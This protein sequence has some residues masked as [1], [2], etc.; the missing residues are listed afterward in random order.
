MAL[1]KVVPL[2]SEGSLDVKIEGG[3]L[4][5]TISHVHASGEV[6]LVAKEDVKYFLEKLKVAIPGKFDDVVIDLAEASLP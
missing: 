6:S 5:L 1:E 4:V 2:G 3:K